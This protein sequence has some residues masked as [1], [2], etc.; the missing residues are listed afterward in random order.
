MKVFDTL[1]SNRTDEDL[2]SRY[3]YFIRYALQI[4]STQLKAS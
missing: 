3:L 1:G 2:Y 4:F